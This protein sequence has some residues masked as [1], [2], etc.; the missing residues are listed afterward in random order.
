MKWQGYPPQNL[1]VIGKPWVPD[2]GAASKME[3]V[4]HIFIHENAPPAIGGPRAPQPIQPGGAV[5]K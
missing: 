5:A 3:G 4:K 1:N 2:V